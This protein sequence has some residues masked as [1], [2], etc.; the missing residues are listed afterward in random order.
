MS[1]RTITLPEP[2]YEALLEIA[3]EQGLTPE[4][5]IAAQLSKE[6]VLPNV[7]PTEKRLLSEL[8]GDLIGA[9][10]SQAEPH[11]QYEKTPF[12]EQLAAKLSKQGIRR[13]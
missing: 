6:G 11:H 8:T 9:I 7:A 4:N 13:P 5:W 3:R 2:T 1:N 12:G 10:D